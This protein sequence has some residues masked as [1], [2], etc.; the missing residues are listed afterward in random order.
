[1]PFIFLN[2]NRC[3]YNNNDAIATTVNDMHTCTHHH[4]DDDDNDEGDD[5]DDSN[6]AVDSDMVEERKDM[7]VL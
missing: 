7:M 4:H 2:A 6:D 3:K 5:D 1:M